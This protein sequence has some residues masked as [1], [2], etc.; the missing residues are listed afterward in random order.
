M[1]YAYLDVGHVRVMWDSPFLA[2]PLK[3]SSTF[4]QYILIHRNNMLRDITETNIHIFIRTHA[5]THT[6]T[7]THTKRYQYTRRYH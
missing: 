1:H 6:H 2:Y 3:T 5:C 4:I 7:H